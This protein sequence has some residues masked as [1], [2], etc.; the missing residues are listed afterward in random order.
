MWGGSLTRA[1][2]PSH[3]SDKRAHDFHFVIIGLASIA[4][5]IDPIRELQTLM[6]RTLFWIPLQSREA[7]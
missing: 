4:F 2:E 1:L 5:I 3:E 6:S 7:R